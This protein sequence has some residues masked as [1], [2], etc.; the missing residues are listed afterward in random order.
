[1]SELTIFEVIKGMKPPPCEKYACGKFELCATQK[2]A[3]FAFQ[4]YVNSGRSVHPSTIP[5]GASKKSAGP[6]EAIYNKVYNNDD[7]DL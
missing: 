3:C 5:R 1:M 4:A 7:D 2:M 6:N